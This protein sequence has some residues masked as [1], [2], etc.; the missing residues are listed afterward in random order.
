[1]AE[2]TTPGILFPQGSISTSWSL[3]R[4]RRGGNTLAY[5][6][7]AWGERLRR[8]QRGSI[9]LLVAI[10]YFPERGSRF[11]FSSQAVVVNWFESVE[12]LDRYL[13]AMQRKVREG[14]AE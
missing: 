10:G 12:E 11:D 7:C 9:D 4:E 6:D 1:M 14:E 3:W 13:A 2:R 5:V 8:L